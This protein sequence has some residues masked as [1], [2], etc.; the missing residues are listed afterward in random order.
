VKADK[1]SVFEEVQRHDTVNLLTE[2]KLEKRR[3]IQTNSSLLEEKHKEILQERS[4]KKK[5]P[6]QCR[7]VFAYARCDIIPLEKVGYAKAS[8][9]EKE[10]RPSLN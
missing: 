8:V 2:L 6:R 7:G 5:T 3:N 9:G 10:D 1:V 4:K